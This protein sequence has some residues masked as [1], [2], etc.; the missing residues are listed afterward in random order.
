MR[1]TET[2]HRSEVRPIGSY[3]GS[4][5]GNGGA[6]HDE[7]GVVNI[8]QQLGRDA[9]RLLRAEVELTK[10]QATQKIRESVGYGTRMAVGGAFAL[11]GAMALVAGIIHLLSYVMPIWLAAF[12][13]GALIVAIGAGL[14]LSGWSAMQESNLGR[15][16]KEAAA[17]LTHDV[18][19][20]K[21]A[22]R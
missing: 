13:V 21:E 19:M 3:P 17:R 9:E 8:V 10:R 20:L 15:V 22:A 11:L 12:I 5:A 2:H 4:Y 6:V 14:A 18:K 1:T 7:A 16:P